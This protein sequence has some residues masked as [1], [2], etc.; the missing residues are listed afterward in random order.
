[1][2]KLVGVLVVVGCLVVAGAASSVTLKYPKFSNARGLKLN[3]DAELSGAKQGHRLRLVPAEGSQTGSA[4]TKR[5]VLKANKSFK[6]QFRFELHDTSLFPADGFAFVLHRGSKSALGDGGGGL[7][8][9]SINHSVAVEFD[10]F[11][12][13]EGD[14]PDDNHVDVH[15]N[16]NAGQGEAATSLQVELYGGTRWVWIAYSAKTGKLKVFVDDDKTKQGAEKL[17]YK[18][19]IK[20][21]LG[22]KAR[23]G[24]TAATGGG[25]ADMDILSWKLKQK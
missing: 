17:S 25:D 8:Y 9:G 19:K 21:E 11:D 10:I 1:V 16:G 6:T 15:L 14:D 2:R 7:G 18:H 5:K 13:A 23:A 24:F 12:N 22:R 20:R 4:F 3:G